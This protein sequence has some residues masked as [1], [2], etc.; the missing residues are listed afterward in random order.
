MQVSS[1]VGALIVHACGAVFSNS[2]SWLIRLGDACWL[3]VPSLARVRV[4]L[5]V[6]LVADHKDW[7]LGHAPCVLTRC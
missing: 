6:Y 2:V 4:V 5:S 3:F 7:R 1:K